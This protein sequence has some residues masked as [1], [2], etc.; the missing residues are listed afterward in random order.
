MGIKN[1]L[2]SN[3]KKFIELEQ[4]NLKSIKQLYELLNNEQ[5]RQLIRKRNLFFICQNED[6]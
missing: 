5:K 4:K 1:H 3:E 6:F 2:K